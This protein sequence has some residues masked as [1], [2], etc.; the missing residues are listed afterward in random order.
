MLYILEQSLILKIK[1]VLQIKCGILSDPVGIKDSEEMNRNVPVVHPVIKVSVDHF[2]K[3]TAYV[4]GTYRVLEEPRK[5][6]KNSSEVKFDDTVG[7][8][9]LYLKSIE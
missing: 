2:R 6:Y 8:V 1:E 5:A 4:D 3:N 7:L 9:L